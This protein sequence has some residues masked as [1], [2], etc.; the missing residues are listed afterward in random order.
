[1]CQ[2]RE[3]T[4]R[5]IPPPLLKNMALNKKF[6]FTVL[7]KGNTKGTEVEGTEGRGSLPHFFLFW[8]VQCVLI[9]QCHQGAPRSIFTHIGS[10]GGQPQ[11]PRR[12]DSHASSYRGQL[13]LRPFPFLFC[14]DKK[15]K[16]SILRGTRRRSDHKSAAPPRRDGER[17]V[18]RQTGRR[19][20]RSKLSRLHACVSVWS[21]PRRIR[22]FEPT[23]AKGAT[24]DSH[25][26]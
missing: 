15:K 17:L 14:G 16:K 4:F 2:V 20:T 21:P 7:Q 1:M 22:R 24:R 6:N 10:T 5:C 8:D 11:R 23:K 18:L 25:H 26:G 13:F 3:L 9:N 12:V 19:R